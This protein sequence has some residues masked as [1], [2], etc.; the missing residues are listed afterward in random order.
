VGL[1]SD[2]HS[3]EIPSFLKITQTIPKNVVIPKKL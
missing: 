1:G 2:S 3:E